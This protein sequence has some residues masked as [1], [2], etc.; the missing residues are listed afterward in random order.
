[1]SSLAVTRAQQWL[2]NALPHCREAV[3]ARSFKDGVL[4][5]ACDHSIAQQEA[6]QCAHDLQVY[7]QQECPGALVESIRVIRA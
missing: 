4:M 2:D 1:M 7:L 5:I 6:H 3:R